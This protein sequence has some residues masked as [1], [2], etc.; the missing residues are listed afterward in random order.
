[1]NASDGFAVER[2]INSVDMHALLL[3]TR[4]IRDAE[5]VRSRL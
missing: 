3:C 5:T 1:M 4:T 2:L